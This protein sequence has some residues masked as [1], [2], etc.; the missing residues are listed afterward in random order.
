MKPVKVLEIISGFAVE[1]PLG[2]I[3]RFGIELARSLDRSKVEPVLCGMWSY[4]TP[5]ENQWVD[6]LLA[7][8]IHS[9]IVGNW[10]E[11][12]PYR[13]FFQ[14]NHK[15]ASFVNK[16]DVIHSHCQFGDLLALLNQ[17]RLGAKAIVRTVHNEREW[18]KR[19]FRRLLLTNSLY[20]FMFDL[21]IGVA[22][23]VVVNLNK[24]LIAQL[25]NKKAV[26]S[27]NALNLDRF[28][29]KSL[30]KHAKKESLGLN[31]IAKIVGS[32]GRLAPQKGYSYFL[33]AAALLVKDF[34]EINFLIIGDGELRTELESQTSQLGLNKQVFFMGAREDVEELIPVMDVFVNSSQWEGLP[35]VIMESMAARVPVVATN[36]GGNA[37][38]IKDQATGWLVP[39]NNA[40][41]LADTIG[42]VLTEDEKRL[43]S[44][45]QRAYQHIQQQFSIQSIARQHESFY[46]QLLT[47]VR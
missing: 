39:P 27:F 45:C 29:E 18:G 22:E 25:L 15:L 47:K 28:T 3:E 19:P 24:R 40:F 46:H 31:P 37:E 41:Q 6:R 44:V 8:G 23:Q 21:E 42:K 13:S 26:K 5:F 10:E 14:I 7:E 12:S 16:V 34:P 20:P 9:F 38:L 11:S 4:G 2:G 1:G 35:T 36:V 30:D 43:A 32:V 33:D 17:R